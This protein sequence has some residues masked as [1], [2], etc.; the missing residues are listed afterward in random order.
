MGASPRF[1]QACEGHNHSRGREKSCN[2]T[3]IAFPEPTTPD[4]N[5]GVPI[6]F[7]QIGGYYT[8][9]HN[10]ATCIAYVSAPSVVLLR[11][12]ILYAP[13]E[14]S[15]SHFDVPSQTLSDT[16]LERDYLSWLQRDK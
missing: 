6:Y 7:G 9:L 8:T 4:S 5:T 14:E 11:Q 3:I 1:N 16:T 12:I 13:R 15:T 2:R 10:N